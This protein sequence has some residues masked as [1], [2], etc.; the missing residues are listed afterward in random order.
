MKLQNPIYTAS[1]GLDL[2]F[3]TLFF[4]RAPDL[5]FLQLV[6]CLSIST[7]CSPSGFL[8]CYFI[9]LFLC[10]SISTPCFPGELLTCYFINLLLCFQFLHPFL[11]A[12]SW[13]AISS[14]C[15]YAFNFFTLF[16]R[17]APDL[18]FFNLFHFQFRHLVAW[19]S[20]YSLCASGMLL[21]SH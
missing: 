1:F 17:R 15:F 14:T 18:L 16:Y 8:T 7:P 5:P 2:S 12:G 19:F 4:R 20:I 9:N 13:L 21:K 10:F 3:I 11:Q 6:A